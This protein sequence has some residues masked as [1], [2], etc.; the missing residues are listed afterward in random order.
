MY[1]NES[2]KYG[3]FIEFI[4]KHLFCIL[5]YIL[6]VSVLRIF[7][8]IFHISENIINN[9]YSFFNIDFFLPCKKIIYNYII[10]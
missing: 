6:V 1:F 4:A 2:K 10:F 7:S 3:R 9:I 5:V 8:P